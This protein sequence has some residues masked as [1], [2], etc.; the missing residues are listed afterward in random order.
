LPAGLTDKEGETK[1]QTARRELLEETGY[2]AN[3]F[4]PIIDTPESSVLTPTNVIHFLAKN[5]EY[6]GGEKHDTAEQIEVIEVPLDVLDNYLLNLPADT[7][8]DLRVTGLLWVL[9]RKKLI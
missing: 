9:E 1:E 3:E 2:L 8:L 7:L 6:V 5:V 4:I